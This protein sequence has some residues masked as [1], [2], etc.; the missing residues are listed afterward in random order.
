VQHPLLHLP[1]KQDK[2]HLTAADLPFIARWTGSYLCTAELIAPQWAITA[3]HCAVRLLKGD[4]KVKLSFFN[5]NKQ[6]FRTVA[7]DEAVSAPSKGVDIAL[8]RLKRKVAQSPVVL[9]STRFGKGT[10]LTN[11]RGKKV[12]RVGTRSRL[13]WMP[14]NQFTASGK[15][16]RV[17]V[18]NTQGSGM[19]PGDSGGAWL[20]EVQSNGKRSVV[21]VGV[22]H[23]GFTQGKKRFGVA[24]Q[25]SFVRDWINRTTNHT[26]VWTD[27]RI[28]D[29]GLQQK[30]EEPHG[31]RRFSSKADDSEDGKSVEH[32][33][34]Q[35]ALACGSIGLLGTLAVFGF[36]LIG[37]VGRWS[38]HL[39]RSSASDASQFT[40]H[41]PN[42]DGELM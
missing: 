21:L 39:V 37:V 22:I 18:D 8:V 27:E 14:P 20:R 38:I 7:V 25:P 3:R 28:D 9:D 1:V 10:T 35:P 40:D 42:S 11:P 34:M 26:A 2:T 24:F 16:V 4:E 23:G 33:V 41:P 30:S 36:G 15:G 17:L 31:H 12:I 32:V 5:K 29:A 19:F 13:H 6:P